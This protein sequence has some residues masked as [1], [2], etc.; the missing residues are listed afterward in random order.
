MKARSESANAISKR[1]IGILMFCLSLLIL[2]LLYG[3][4]PSARSEDQ[5]KADIQER[6]YPLRDRNMKINSFNITQRKTQTDRKMDDI[7][8]SLK[9]TGDGFVYTAKLHCFYVL[10]DQGWSLESLSKTSEEYTPTSGPSDKV[11]SDYYENKHYDKTLVNKSID[12]KNGEC[13]YV[14]DITLTAKSYKVTANES[15]VYTWSSKTGLWEISKTEKTNEYVSFIAPTEENPLK[16]SGDYPLYVDEI[17]YINEQQ[18]E[19]TAYYSYAGD[20]YRS[21]KIPDY[22]YITVYGD[23]RQ[24][25][26]VKKDQHSQNW[27]VSYDI[28]WQYE[29]PALRILIRNNM[30]GSKY[31]ARIY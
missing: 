5:I 14:Y 12:I 21:N 19:L 3:C 2:L 22:Y 28:D 11:L 1:I 9:A 26:W 25:C 24:W 18:L 7:D 27:S 13:K 29:S 6:F 31:Y 30:G 4:S 10:Y 8:V 17:E 16:V 20:F 15:L 23:E